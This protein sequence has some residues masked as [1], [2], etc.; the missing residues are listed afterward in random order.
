MT[1]DDRR[2]RR[3]TFEQ[4]REPLRIGIEALGRRRKA[5]GGAVPGQLGDEHAAPLRERRCDG[6]P[7]RRGPAEAVDE[8][9]RRTLAAGEPAEP[10]PPEVRVALGKA[11]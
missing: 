1:D 11:G 5:G 6:R 4:E 7:V 2:P 3:G 10:N 8:Q 9:E